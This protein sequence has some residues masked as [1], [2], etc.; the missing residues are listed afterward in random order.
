MGRLRK[1]S[2]LHCYEWWAACCAGCIFSPLILSVV[3]ML[4]GGAAPL[5][6]AKTRRSTFLHTRSFSRRGVTPKAAIRE[7]LVQ[8][9]I[10]PVAVLVV[11]RAD[12]GSPLIV[13][14]EGFLIHGC[15]C[16]HSGVMHCNQ[17]PPG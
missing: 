15:S 13:R 9:P 6:H 4:D 1:Q 2:P 17:P 12:G 11:S 14:V 3:H 8:G 16:Q 5:T 10:A 7:K